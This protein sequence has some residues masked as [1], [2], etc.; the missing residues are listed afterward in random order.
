MDAL[1]QALLASASDQFMVISPDGIIQAVNSTMC[2]RLGASQ[3]NLLFASVYGC[4]PPDVAG[5]RRAMVDE[6]VATRQPLLCEDVS[7]SGKLFEICITPVEGAAGDISCL[8]LRTKDISKAA[9]V[10]EERYRLALA[11]EQAVE[12][13]ILLSEDM[14]IQYVN[15]AFEE[16]TGFALQEIKSKPIA[17]LYGEPDQKAVFEHALHCL[18]HSESWMGQVSATGKPGKP[19]KQ[20]K[21][22]GHFRCEQ[23]Y[24]RIRGKRYKSMGYVSIWR[25]ITEMC[26]LEKQLRRAQKMEAV[27]ALAGGIAHDF[28]NIL[29]PIMLHAEMSLQTLAEDDSHWQSFHEILSAAQRAQNLVEQ[30]LGLSRKRELDRPVCFNLSSIVKEC[31]K[32][33]RPSIPANIQVVFDKDSEDDL[34]RAEPTQ[35]H[36]VFM[37]L[38]TNAIQAMEGRGGK[39][40]IHIASHEQETADR[41]GK[42]ETAALPYRL[43]PGRYVLLQ[44]ADTGRGIEKDSMPHLFDPFFTTKKG[45]RGTGLGLAVVK[46]IV[47]GMGGNVLVESTPD[48]GACFTVLLP[49][50]QEGRSGVCACDGVEEAASLAHV[51][52][53]DDDQVTL[54]G[55]RQVLT[56]LGCKVVECRN[57]YEALAQ[58]RREPELYDACVVEALL[59]EMSGLE[60]TRELLLHRP[61]LPVVLC[62]AYAHVVLAEDA[63]KLGVSKFLR[64]P[65]RLEELKAVF[66][67]VLKQEAGRI[68][69]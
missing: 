58:F 18:K 29:G 31:L 30:I 49:M 7:E 54:Q 65:F 34:L 14:C 32:L 53:V 26:E 33:L 6:A 11:L 36:Q 69:S 67:K 56:E 8:V 59:T 66:A 38:A 3:Q 9:Q 42:T 37:N 45:S 41:E 15:Q 55:S 23:T 50:C 10:E 16:M 51:L 2:D 63:R 44:V 22:E 20:G 46:N 47:S 12:A 61:D 13:V 68:G 17:M 5:R 64:K 43:P 1:H 28:N 60:L 39:L 25:D 24:V 19:G 27:G 48:Q 40:H 35:V 4:F 52:L 21:E 57:G 62:S